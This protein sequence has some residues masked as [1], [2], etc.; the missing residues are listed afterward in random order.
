LGILA[1]VD[2]GKTTLTER[3][4]HAAG[5]IHELGNV[6]D[7]TTQ[8]DTLALE[9]QRGITI[10]TAVATFAIDDVTVNLIDTPGHPDFIAEVE[11]VLAVLDGA[12][13]VV[14]AVEG[15]QAQTP[16]LWRA[17][18][19]LEVPTL[20]FV[21]KVD[22]SGADPDRVLAAIAERLTPAVVRAD[23]DQ[24]TLL[25]TLAENDESLLDGADSGRLREELAAQTR[26]GLVHPVFV[27]SAL[28]GSGVE[29]LSSGIAELLPAEPGDA[30]GPLSGTVFKIERGDDRQ[31]VA[32]VRLFSGTL[33]VRD[34]L[35][36]EKVTALAGFVGGR[37]V[38][39][40]ALGP[41]EIA[42]VWGLR[43][44]RIGDAVGKPHPSVRKHFAPPTLET[45][46]RPAQEANKAAL[47]LAL[48]QLAEQDPLIDVQQDDERQA[49]A[50]SLYGEVQKEVIAATLVDDFG[51][52]ATFSETTPLCVERPLR[53][54]EA[55]EWLNAESNP[56]PATL[57]LRVEPAAGGAGET[58]RLGADVSMLP[59]Y[60]YKTTE[61]FREHMDEYVWL[62]TQKGP[63]G[64][65]VVDWV[66]TLTE[67][68]YAGSDGPPSKRGPLAK[69]SEFRDLTALVLAQALEQART[70][71]CEPVHRFRLECPVDTLGSVLAALA[72]LGAVLEA[73]E[74]NGSWS[75]ATGEISV[76]R[77]LELQQ[78]LRGLTR[79]EGVLDS[80][81]DRY[82]PVEERHARS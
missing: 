21:N 3:L 53:T 10:K 24:E 4:L 28:R 59:M 49:F 34:R 66:V 46:V 72:R 26:R 76:A 48:T 54:G 64:W 81:F 38:H 7:G 31:K 69:P 44:A 58:F 57:A 23:A 62:A 8:T 74:V 16:L 61:S 33:R 37:A 77:L 22:R 39:R 9:Q 19:R 6:D 47:H 42:K 50:L 15:V 20:F 12:V 11:R 30:E 56:F 68:E 32:Y 13:L 65:R 67:L 35:G 55:V 43:G 45:V 78:Q 36:D 41:G 5:V 17:L 29:E 79:G 25:W 18:E 51:V 71:V 73:P 82:E 14:S 70:V 60:A 80:V 2:G 52:E 27:G 40:E 1:H 75:T 63:L